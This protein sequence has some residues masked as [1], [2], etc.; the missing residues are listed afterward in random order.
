MYIHP[1]K[2][3]LQLLIFSSIFA[4]PTIDAQQNTVSCGGDISGAAGSVAY[5]I[6][7]VVFNQ[8]SNENAAVQ[9]G[10]QQPYTVEI[11]TG[12]A[13]NTIQFELF[14]NPTKEIA[15]LRIQPENKGML[16]YSLINAAGQLINAQPLNNTETPIPMYGLANGIYM[17]NVD[18][19]M[20]TLKSFR[21]VK[22]E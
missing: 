20:E 2:R 9:E 13:L 3:E 15:I 7:Q 1:M 8:V 4:V 10:V 5:S 21:I 18:N 17:L 6:G 16:H 19:G 14:P 11:I 22:T 12:T